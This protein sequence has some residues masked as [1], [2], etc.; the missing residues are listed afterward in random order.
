MAGNTNSIGL[1]INNTSPLSTL[2]GGIGASHTFSLGS[3][4]FIN[5]GGNFTE[6]NSTFFWDNTNTRLYIGANSSTQSFQLP[7]L[8]NIQSS[9]SSYMGGLNFY[10]TQDA[11]PVLALQNRIHGDSGIY[12]DCYL[13]SGGNILSSS[14]TGNF[15]IKNNGSSLDIYGAT[16]VSPGNTISSVLIFRTGVNGSNGKI[17]IPWLSA[18]Q[19]V[20]TDSSLNLTSLAYASSNT[21]STIVQRDSNANFSSN[22]ITANQFV[23]VNT[24]DPFYYTTSG[25]L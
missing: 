16:G 20:A 5:S 12:F 24:T 19:L 7:N 6:N 23:G 4:P 2:Y 11:F 14:A 18:S 1:V 3:I 25:G 22:V 15:F 21:A 10:T 13:N 17:T 9:S 8:L